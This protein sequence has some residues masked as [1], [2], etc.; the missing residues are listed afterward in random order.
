VLEVEPALLVLALEVVEEPPAAD[1]V[2]ATEEA[3]EVE[4]TEDWLTANE[5]EL[6]PG[7]EL[8]VLPPAP[9]LMVVPPVLL[10]TQLVS[11]PLRIVM[12]EVY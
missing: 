3:E 4:D 11:L 10:P 2:E 8:V 9:L 7:S 1:D 12:G 6:E 5:D